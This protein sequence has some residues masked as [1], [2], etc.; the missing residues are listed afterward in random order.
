MKKS[1]YIFIILPVE[2]ACSSDIDFAIF[3]Q[4]IT[5]HIRVIKIFLGKHIN[6]FSR[7]GKKKTTMKLDINEITMELIRR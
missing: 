1:M 7:W 6:K 5:F 3:I 2:T 4:G